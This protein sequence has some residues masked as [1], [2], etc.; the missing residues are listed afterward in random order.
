[1]KIPK[2]YSRAI[3]AGAGSFASVYRAFDASLGRYC[4]LKIIPVQRKNQLQKTVTEA[5][6]LSKAHP[7]SAPHMYD[8]LKMKASVILVMEWVNGVPMTAF[9]YGE[10]DWN[11]KM[12][13]AGELLAG[14]ANLHRNGIIHGDLKPDNVM[15]SPERGA[16]FIDF[17]FSQA[18][19][20]S[21]G[22]GS[23]L[24]TPAYMAP[25]LWKSD[26]GVDGKK[27]DCYAAGVMLGE[28]FGGELPD[29][30]VS[31]LS[32][33]PEMRPA[34]IGSV[35]SEV[36]ALTSDAHRITVY[37]KITDA[38]NAYM[39]ELLCKGAGELLQKKMREEAYALLLES[40]E[41]WPDNAGALALLQSR[42]SSPVRR[43]RF[44]HIQM[45]AA[46][47]IF[48]AVLVI[49]AFLAGRTSTTSQQ[50]F[51][52]E[53]SIE[54]DRGS[55]KLSIAG[56]TMHG[57]EG[58]VVLRSAETMHEL[59]GT[60]CVRG[61]EPPGVLFVD[62]RKFTPVTSHEV[63]VEL[64]EGTHRIEW[65]NEQT[66]LRVGETIDLLPFSKKT[67]LFARNNHGH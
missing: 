60:L 62:G 27:A 11:E 33:D 67:L 36:K 59:T 35:V 58:D 28:L 13:V 20:S 57:P 48:V 45:Y 25:E 41:L 49:V 52:Q 21:G 66:K 9:D 42:F 14:L 12:V 5:Q 6:L 1:M 3:K 15:L 43:Q 17:G 37:K 32:S 16:V 30:L 64:P 23:L 54:S 50:I 22:K 44:V 7:S 10:M 39:S 19:T 8:I 56:S 29:S 40:I 47:G 38:S 65:H 55:L 53:H 18:V 2:G 63:K 31:L 4:A 24:G 26:A 46:S 51:T 34:D 61:I